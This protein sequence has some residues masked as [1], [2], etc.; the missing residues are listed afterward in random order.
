MSSFHCCSLWP[1]VPCVGDAYAASIGL[2]TKHNHK[3][4]Q[5]CQLR[6]HAAGTDNLRKRALPQ[7]LAIPEGSEEL[8]N[9]IQYI[10]YMFGI[11]TRPGTS[12]RA[13]V[14]SWGV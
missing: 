6:H 5:S 4:Y 14:R 9:T 12:Q 8:F 13:D 2:I 3:Q 7:G 10:Q 11:K 1:L